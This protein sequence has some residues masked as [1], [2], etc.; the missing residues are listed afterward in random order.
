MYIYD[1]YLHFWRHWLVKT[2]V[3]FSM[4]NFGDA[5]VKS[6]L[7]FLLYSFYDHNKYVIYLHYIF[8]I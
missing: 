6:C 4:K 7:T 5:L 1:P 2:S 3:P 8:F